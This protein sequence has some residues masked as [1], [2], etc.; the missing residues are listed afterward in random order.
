MVTGNGDTHSFTGSLEG[1]R[2]QDEAR[3]SY[4]ERSKRKKSQSL[5]FKQEVNKKSVRMCVEERMRGSEVR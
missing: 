5:C 3:I 2:G 4:H 1:K